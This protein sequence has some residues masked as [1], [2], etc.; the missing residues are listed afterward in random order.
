MNEGN[1]S[2]HNLTPTQV[3]SAITTMKKKKDRATI[4]ELEADVG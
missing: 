4:K 2:T 3:A 1:E